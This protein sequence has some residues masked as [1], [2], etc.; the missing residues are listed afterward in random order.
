MHSS[1]LQFFSFNTSCNRGRLLWN[2]LLFIGLVCFGLSPASRAA[3]PPPPPAGGYPNGNTAE[4]S[5]ALF[6]L[7]TGLNN[8]AVGSSVRARVARSLWR[9]PMA[10]NHR[11]GEKLA[12]TSYSSLV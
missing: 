9:F 4:G 1:V 8:T 6:S 7:T 2:G 11:Y 12:L 10:P 5:N 3:L